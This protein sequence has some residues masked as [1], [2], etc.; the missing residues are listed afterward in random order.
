M[1]EV[2][3]F[4]SENS[5]HPEWSLNGS[6]LS[7]K[8][9]THDNNNKVSLKD[10]ELASHM[11]YVYDY[12]GKSKSYSYWNDRRAVETFVGIFIVGALVLHKY[13][14]NRYSVIMNGTPRENKIE[15]LEDYAF[16]KFT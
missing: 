11:V 14:W 15:T 13:Y 7:V 2:S 16:L 3:K 12:K 8:L 6:T 1:N 5:H 4:C 9:T 10:Y